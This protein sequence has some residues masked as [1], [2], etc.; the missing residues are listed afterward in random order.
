MLGKKLN[1]KS[2]HRLYRQFMLTFNSV[3]ILRQS[4][5]LTVELIYFLNKTRT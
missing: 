3:L 4:V 2:Q 5:L 1:A